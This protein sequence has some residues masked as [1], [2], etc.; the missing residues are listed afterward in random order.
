MNEIL[1]GDCLERLKELPDGCV[2][3]ILQDPPYANNTTDCEWDKPINLSE[4]WVQ[5]LRVTKA[6][7]PIIFTA[8]MRFAVDLINSNPKLFKYEWIWHKI[9]TS[10]FVNA[11]VKPMSCH[12]FVLVFA[13]GTISYYPQYNERPAADIRRAGD[14]DKH[15]YYGQKR[16]SRKDC[17]YSLDASYKV[18]NE[19]KFQP[20]KILPK[21]VIY[22]NSGN[23]WTR[24]KSIHP[25]QKPIELFEYLIKTYTKEGDV[26]FDGYSGSGTTAMACIKNNRNYICVE[27]DAEYH[28]NSLKRINQVQLNLL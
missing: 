10:G 9:N 22:F 25:T 16:I 24:K 19:E 13:K 8:N 5:W 17:V 11:Y 2:D 26:V 23:G 1:L 3:L 21:T 15:T 4:L 20:D 6:N 12:E 14:R 27:Q 28:K 7:A 18:H